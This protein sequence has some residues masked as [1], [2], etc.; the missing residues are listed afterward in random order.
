MKKQCPVC[1]NLIPKENNFC[2]DCG[3][4]L[5][6]TLNGTPIDGGRY[7]VVIEIIEDYTTEEIAIAEGEKIK[8]N[9]YDKYKASV[10]NIERVKKLNSYTLADKFP[11]I[12][13]TCREYVSEEPEGIC[14]GCKTVNWKKRKKVWYGDDGWDGIVSHS[15]T[16]PID[17][18]VTHWELE[19]SNKI[20][21]EY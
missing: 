13:A 6:L 19:D 1:G 7:R 11:F 3:I 8:K 16:M 10:V 21:G 5:S 20:E 18:R 12:C 14:R 17:D 2:G 15:E 4:N 9:I